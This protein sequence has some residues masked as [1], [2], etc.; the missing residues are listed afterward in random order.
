MDEEKKDIITL[1]THFKGVKGRNLKTY[2]IQNPFW[3]IL[4]ATHFRAKIIW[5]IQTVSILGRV[6]S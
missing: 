5:I 4:K 2:T 3:G 1:V 6:S